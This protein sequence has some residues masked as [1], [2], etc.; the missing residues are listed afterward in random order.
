MKDLNKYAFCRPFL[1]SEMY[2]QFQKMHEVF[3]L[4]CYKLYL[5][6]IRMKSYCLTIFHNSDNFCCTSD[7][8]WNRLIRRSK[9]MSFRSTCFHIVEIEPFKHFFWSYFNGIHDFINCR[10]TPVSSD[11]ISKIYNVKTIV[12]KKQIT[13]IPVKQHRPKYRSLWFTISKV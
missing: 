5:Y 9:Q 4:H 2:L 11:M 8:Y 7:I 6:N 10:S 3:D 12:L 1:Y 13:K